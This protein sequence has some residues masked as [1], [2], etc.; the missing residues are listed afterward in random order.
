MRHGIVVL[1]LPFVL[2]TGCSKS[3]PP[4][5]R[6]RSQAALISAEQ[7]TQ[8]TVP[9]DIRVIGNVEAYATISVKAQVGG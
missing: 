8:K 5:G 3:G 2:L 1:L 4:A 7:A 6:A 9:V